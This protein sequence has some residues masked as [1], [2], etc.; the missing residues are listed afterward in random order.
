LTRRLDFKRTDYYGG[1]KRTTR[2]IIREKDDVGRIVDKWKNVVLNGTA[3]RG[4][5]PCRLAF[6]AACEG[7]NFLISKNTTPNRIR[8][9]PGAELSVWMS[10]TV[11]LPL[12]FSGSFRCT[13]AYLR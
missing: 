11:K 3:S 12:S 8:Q 5:N 4:L 2:K 9:F 6:I 7:N 1:H 10:T 13:V